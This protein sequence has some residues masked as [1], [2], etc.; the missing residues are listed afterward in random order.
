MFGIRNLIRLSDPLMVARFDDNW[1]A[2][3]LTGTTQRLMPDRVRIILA[4][5]DKHVANA[6]VH[7]GK[8]ASAAGTETHIRATDQVKTN[9]QTDTPAGKMEN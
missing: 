2:H 6:L 8:A 5:F 1:K 3:V 9:N 7:V 4:H